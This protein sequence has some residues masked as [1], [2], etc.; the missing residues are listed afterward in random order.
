MMRTSIQCSRWIE[1]SLSIP[2]CTFPASDPLLGLFT[3]C[4]VQNWQA[5]SNASP[6]WYFLQSERSSTLLRGP[7]SRSQMLL[8]SLCSI[9]WRHKSRISVWQAAGSTKSCESWH[10]LGSMRKSGKDL[11]KTRTGSS[12]TSGT[13]RREWRGFRTVD[14]SDGVSKLCRRDERLFIERG[15]K[16]NNTAPTT[17]LKCW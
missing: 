6:M 2:F 16:A 8:F 1:K 13:R 17:D 7:P 15:L 10:L 9:S 12:M 3:R 5:Y 14:M 4:F 11:W